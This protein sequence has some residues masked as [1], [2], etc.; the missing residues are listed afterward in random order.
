MKKEVFKDVP[1]YEGMYQ[2]SNLGNVKS[3]SREMY[4]GFSYFTSKEKILKNGKDAHDYFNVN[5]YKNGKAKMFK[6]HQ[7]VVMA[8]LGHK[9]DGTNKIVVDHINNIRSDNRLE[10]L[11]LITNRE[12]TSKDK[13]GKGSSKYT[14]V[15]FNKN[16]KKWKSDITINNVKFFIGYFKDEIDAHNAYQK[17]LKDWEENKVKPSPKKFSSK[18]KGVSWDKSKNK[19]TASIWRNGKSNFIGRFNCEEEANIAYQKAQI[20]NRIKKS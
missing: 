1:G 16:N 4:N 5:L 13:I 3:L 18:Y 15:L 20:I 14:G 10:N 17:A 2:V 11:Q 7:L 19:W 8:F 6:I 12:N 9:P